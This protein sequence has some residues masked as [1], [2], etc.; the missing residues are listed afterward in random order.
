MWFWLPC[1]ERAIKQTWVTQAGLGQ[2]VTWC[3]LFPRTNAAKAED[4]IKGT[5]LN[6]ETKNKKV[7]NWKNAHFQWTS[8]AAEISLV[9][10]AV[11]L[12]SQGNHISIFLILVWSLPFSF[13][14]L[15]KNFPGEMKSKLFIYLFSAISN[16]QPCMMQIWQCQCVLIS[17]ELGMTREKCM[18]GCLRAPRANK[19]L[20][21]WNKT[22]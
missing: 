22:I 12:N 15:F 17:L 20:E 21:G 1:E 6:W 7:F 18:W 4:H 19:W 8:L 16:S 13:C 5:H 3:V 2:D 10:V 9:K 14:F 11:Q